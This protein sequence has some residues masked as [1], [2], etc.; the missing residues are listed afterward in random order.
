M[1]IKRIIFWITATALI[2]TL[3]F[4]IWQSK[5]P[6]KSAPVAPPVSTPTPAPSTPG[7]ETEIKVS[8]YLPLLKGPLPSGLSVL[9]R[10]NIN[11]TANAKAALIASTL[12]SSVRNGKKQILLRQTYTYADNT[13][14]QYI[15]LDDILTE[16]TDY[17]R[18]GKVLQ[19][20]VY[21]SDYDKF[22][23]LNNGFLPVDGTLEKWVTYS[24]AN[25]R[26][27]I[28]KTYH[29]NG[30]VRTVVGY[31]YAT[32]K[33][34][35]FVY[36]SLGYLTEYNIADIDTEEPREQNFFFEDGM[37][38]GTFDYEKTESAQRPVRGF[39]R[40]IKTGSQTPVIGSWTRDA[41]GETRLSN[42]AVIPSQS[43]WG[44]GKPYCVK[45][46]FQCVNK[47]NYATL[48]F[49]KTHRCL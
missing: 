9:Y 18:D 5:Q 32:N 23:P 29:P 26:P 15:F 39:W 33:Q 40:Y 45:Y 17:D 10:A 4:F 44:A 22:I 37:N 42:G 20:E 38:P 30:T 21:R 11:P 12:S 1:N 3:V 43:S 6:K 16:R 41:T 13:K 14:T 47:Q 24:P 8:S 31:D 28:T 48:Q 19:D 2:A 49:C 27:L 46:P 36:D 34:S 7:P 35:I 25:D